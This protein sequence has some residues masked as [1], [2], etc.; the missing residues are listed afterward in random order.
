MGRFWAVF[1]LLFDVIRATPDA[2]RKLAKFYQ[3]KDEAF[4]E[5]G[6]T[7]AADFL[8]WYTSESERQKIRS[9]FPSCQK[10]LFSFLPAFCL[11]F[12]SLIKSITKH[13]KKQYTKNLYLIE[14]K[15]QF[16]MQK[17]TANRTNKGKQE[18][19]KIIWKN[20]K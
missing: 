19:I 16:L 6:A 1:S 7:Y 4:F 5:S 20:I 11:A 2:G 15:M 9:N 17:I 12:I 10:H 8:I 14:G 3:C 13:P 18:S